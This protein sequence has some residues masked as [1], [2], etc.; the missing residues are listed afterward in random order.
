MTPML[1]ELKEHNARVKWMP[2]PS[3]LNGKMVELDAA[4]EM[5]TS[6]NLPILETLGQHL[7][8]LIV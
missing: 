8:P 4:S 5:P 1:V 6:K 3:K 7:A 2:R